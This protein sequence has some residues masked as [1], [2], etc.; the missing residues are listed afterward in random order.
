M[1]R[2]NISYIKFIYLEERYLSLDMFEVSHAQYLYAD[3]DFYIFF[4]EYMRIPMKSQY[5]IR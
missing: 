1:F 4:F 2:R 5:A 3:L